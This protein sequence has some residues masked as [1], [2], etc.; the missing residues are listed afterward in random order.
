[1]FSQYRADP[2]GGPG[3][4]TF[5][6]ANR[7]SPDAAPATGSPNGKPRPGSRG[8]SQ[9]GG[10]GS[11]PR[12]HS[13][14]GRGRQ[15]RRG[16]RVVGPHASGSPLETSAPQ[17]HDRPPGTVAPL[18]TR[19]VTRLKRWV[20]GLR[21]TEERRPPRAT[22]RW[23]PPTSVA[24]EEVINLPLEADSALGTIKQLPRRRPGRTNPPATG[25]DQVKTRSQTRWYRYE[26]SAPH[27]PSPTARNRMARWLSEW[28]VRVPAVVRRS[29]GPPAAAAWT[30]P[31]LHAPLHISPLEGL[32]EAVGVVDN[33]TALAVPAQ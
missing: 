33:Q 12:E 11:Q 7:R 4:R 31:S 16:A 20:G 5:L 1:M 18:A 10:F 30:K 23:N 26:R 25:L 14:R 17:S 9:A 22:G 24:P 13:G 19:L 27:R 2:L 8:V 29:C 6:S 32:D 21:Q 15:A 28:N 3:A